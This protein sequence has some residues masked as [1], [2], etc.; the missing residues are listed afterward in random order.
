[1]RKQRLLS[2]ILYILSGGMAS[3]GFRVR[4]LSNHSKCTPTYLSFSINVLRRRTPFPNFGYGSDKVRQNMENFVC[5]D[6]RQLLQNYI[7]QCRAGEQQ[8][9]VVVVFL[10]F[11]FATPSAL[12][13]S[14]RTCRNPTQNG[15]WHWHNTVLFHQL[16]RF[17]SE[18]ANTVLNF[19]NSTP[20]RNKN[21]RRSC[22]RKLITSCSNSLPP[23]LL[24]L[25][26]YGEPHFC[27]W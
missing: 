27:S 19:L 26:L 20:W 25:R 4:S 7:F 14:C 16:G 12:L 10:F 5:S 8:E 3:L 21:R 13:V 2:Q 17:W 9:P 24:Y 23:S 18:R 6:K 1:M 22:L 11:C 15:H